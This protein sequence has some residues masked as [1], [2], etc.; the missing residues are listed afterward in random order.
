MNF[1]FSDA[2][3]MIRQTAQEFTERY[4]APLAAELDQTGEFPRETF[5]RMAAHGFTGIGIPEE[6]GG[7]GGGDIEKVILVSELAK[8]CGAT[9]A[10]LSI[11]MIF[12]AV[13]L[14]FGTEEQKK[15][16][17]PAMAD[18]GKISAFALTEPN[19]GSDAAAVKTTAL[20]DGDQYILNGTKC[21]ITG[22]G[23]ADHLVVFALTDPAKGLKGLSALVVDKGMPGFSIGKIEDKM[24]IRASETVELIFD[25]CRVPAENLVG[26]E[27]AG[28]KIAMT[29]LDGA[30]IGVA[31]QALGIAEGALEET[32]KYMKERVQ[33]GKPLTALQGLNWYVAEMATKIECA[34]WMTYR[35][36]TLKIKGEPYTKEAA[37]AKYNASETALFVT[38]LALQIHGGY[39]YMKDYPL[40]RMMR[41]AKITQIYEGT[42]EIHKVVIAREVLK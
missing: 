29:A 34:R 39:G 13:I 30:R 4:V 1:D 38:N 14:K 32:V 5:S 22:G 35:A 26:K 6:Y 24:G 9:A 17:L 41:D 20:K 37:M 40:E 19:A 12:P 3:K 15:K 18:G 8:K 11:H 27:G 28:F 16:Y 25:N 21:F 10:T 33:F 42:S 23:Q 2:Q 7:S 36:A 31:A